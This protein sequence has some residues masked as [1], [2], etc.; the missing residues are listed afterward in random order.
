MRTFPRYAPVGPIPSLRQLAESKVLGDYQLVIAPIVLDNPQEASGFWYNHPSE[1]IL[2]NGVI[3]LGYPLPVEDLARA[4]RIVGAK[5][6]VLPDTIDDAKF[7]IKQAR[8]ALRQYRKLAPT[9]LMGVVQGR[10]YE[11]CLDCAAALAL[12]VGVDWLAVPRGL[13]KNLDTRVPLVRKIAD[14]HG[15]PMHILG[16]SDNIADDIEAAACHPL[17]QGIDAAMPMWADTWLPLHP[18]AN[19]PVSLH[20]GPRPSDF[21]NQPAPERAAHNV[22]TV[23]RWLNAAATA[24]IERDGLVAVTDQST[25]I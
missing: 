5:V 12:D 1:V 13:T 24:R 2:D 8:H 23:R 19:E 15:L 25:Q 10:T 4:A 3:E 21:W 7:T 16:F 18:P 17:V 6:V 9:D 20:L 22:E 11:E 14:K